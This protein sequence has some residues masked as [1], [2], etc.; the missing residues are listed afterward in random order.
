MYNSN[1][2]RTAESF[3]K[4]VSKERFSKLIHFAQKCTRCLETSYVCE[5][6]YIFYD[7]AISI[8]K[9]VKSK[10]RSWLSD[11]TLDDSLWLAPLTL[12][13]TNKW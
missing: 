2:I 1:S 5:S 3:W 4:L 10:N 12:V 13:L 7:E 8:M 9:Q 11:K 6:T